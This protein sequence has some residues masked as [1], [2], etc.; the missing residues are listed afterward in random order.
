MRHK[1]VGGIGQQLEKLSKVVGEWTGSTTAFALACGVVL[2]WL[3]TG[4]LFGFS[5]TWQ[6][7]INTG[8]TIVTFLMVFLIQRMQNKE[9]LAVQLKLNEL[10][11]AVQGASNRLI[12]VEDLT[13]EELHTLHKHFAKLVAMSQADS[14]LGI[15]HSVEEAQVRHSWKNK[16]S[17]YGSQGTTRET[18]APHD[19]E[20]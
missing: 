16:Q 1:K 7:V 4:P 11:A 5:D 13:E 6:L 20:S 15:S 3:V 8:T 9:S 12:D 10:V 17:V 19:H 14:S 2:A 18:D